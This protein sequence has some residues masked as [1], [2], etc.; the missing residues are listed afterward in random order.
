[1]GGPGAGA[2]DPRPARA[3]TGLFPRRLA[4]GLSLLPAVALALL[5]AAAWAR[6][7]THGTW[8]PLWYR[9]ALFAALVLT[10][11][12]AVAGTGRVSKEEPAARRASGSARPAPDPHRELTRGRYRPPAIAGTIDTLSPDL[13][14][15]LASPRPRASSPLTNTRT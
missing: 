4:Y 13:S 10:A 11:L 8:L 5:G 2:L 3:L 6:G 15:A 7:F 1:M 12:P 9:A 14:G